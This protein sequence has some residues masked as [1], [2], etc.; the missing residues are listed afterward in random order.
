VHGVFTF[1]DVFYVFPQ[2]TCSPSFRTVTSCPSGSV[3]VTGSVPGLAATLGSLLALLVPA[4][5]C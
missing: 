4:C 1:F 3:Y 2:P 5:M